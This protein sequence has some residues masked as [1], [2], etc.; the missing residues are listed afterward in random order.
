MADK[1]FKVKAGLDLGSPLSIAEGGTG[2]TTA[3]NTLNA[4]LPVQTS[5]SGQILQSD[6]TNVSWVD[7]PSGYAKGNTSS[8]PASPSL[9]DIYSNT[10]TGYIEVYTSAGWS[11]LGVIPLSATIG[12]ASTVANTSYGPARIDVAFTP[13]AGGGLASSFT[14]ISSPGSITGTGTSSPV[15]VTGLTQG[16]A[17]TFTVTATNGYGNALAS[18]SSNSITA[19]TV[20]QAPTITS[21]SEG[22]QSVVVAFTAGATGGSAITGYTVTSSPGNITASGSSSPITVTGL[23][24][25]TSYTFTVTA[26]NANGTS[27]ASTASSAVVPKLYALSQTFTSSGTYTVPAGKSLLAAYVVGGGAGG[28]GAGGG[29]GGGAAF[30]EYAVVPGQQ[31]VVTVG[32]AGSASSFSN[33][34]TGNGASVSTGG[35]GTSSV[36]GAVTASGGNGGSGAGGTLVLTAPGLI[37]VQ[38]GGAGGAGGAG[39]NRAKYV[40]VPIVGSG[41]GAGG[42]GGANG[43]G[44][45]GNGGDS[46]A[47]GPTSGV[48][49]SAGAA[50][51]AGTINT[52]GG[53]GGGGGGGYVTTYN[54][55][56]GVEQTRSGAA[57]ANAAGGSGTVIV[58]IS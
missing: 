11:Q 41:P 16:T 15:R 51:T 34:A 1:D 52:G 8:R 37:S 28:T 44:N 22:D 5:A 31:Y 43:G 45:G 24:N 47:S 19:I 48:F 13:N 33:L 7:K 38:V 30:K 40:N 36:A 35:S 32:G 21:V 20:P 57:G 29:G 42:A 27:A 10:E 39:A 49:A 26:T 2:Q 25:G 4:L 23:T 14:A 6:G 56:G 58:Y 17:Y 46:G 50:G 3:T 55:E 53:G 54:T 12:T 9:G 18:S